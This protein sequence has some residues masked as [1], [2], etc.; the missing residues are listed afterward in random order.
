M[1]PQFIDHIVIIVKDI[2]RTA[3]F[4]GNFLG[5]PITKDKEQVVFKIADT[6][7][8]FGLPY[9]DYEWQDKDKYGL[10]H[11]AFGVR[12]IDELKEFETA[13]NQANIKN[14]GVQVDKWGKKE[15][16]WFNDLDGY[17]LEFYYQPANSGKRSV[18]LLDW[19]Q[20]Y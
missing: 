13:L 8:F 10:N 14:S 7:L 15:F 2:E 9:K 18:N 17:R 5:E 3:S 20:N 12:N 4:Y 1:K 6:K 19:G 16:I 11:L